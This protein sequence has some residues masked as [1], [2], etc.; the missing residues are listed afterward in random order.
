MSKVLQLVQARCFKLF[1]QSSTELLPHMVRIKVS[2]VG[3]CGSDLSFI[4]NPT[5]LPQVLGHEFSGVVVAL[6][7]ACSRIKIGDV[8]ETLVIPLQNGISLIEGALL[9]HLACAVRLYKSHIVS[10]FPHDAPICILGDG[11][12]A[13]GNVQILLAF[14]YSNLTVIYKRL[15]RVQV[16]K[17]LGISKLIDIQRVGIDPIPTPEFELSIVSADISRYTKWLV[18]RMKVRS[19]IVSQV[20]MAL[21]DILQ[22]IVTPEINV[23]GAFAYELDDFR[24]VMDLIEQKKIDT[25]FL[26]QFVITL[27]RLAR[28]PELLWEKDR[29][30]KLIV[31]VDENG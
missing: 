16:L 19:V 12:I 30:T 1:Q 26:Q 17:K 2:H 5:H 21:S 8:P 9:E 13:L 7:E 18:E 25:F 28:N 29:Y 20:R 4:K 23:R 27:E 10:R 14:G 11:P 6:G 15:S 31:K 24:T 22:H 3:I